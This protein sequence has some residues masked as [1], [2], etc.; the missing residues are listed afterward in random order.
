MLV[1]LNLRD[2][3]QEVASS[4]P[5]PGGG[6]VAAYAGAPAPRTIAAESATKPAATKPASRL[7]LGACWPGA[8][9][10]GG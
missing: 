3:A 7:A 2:F 10:L 1:D 5:A 8:S 6:S 4:S 9:L